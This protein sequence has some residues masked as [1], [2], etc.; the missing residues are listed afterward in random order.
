[1][2]FKTISCP[3]AQRIYESNSPDGKKRLN[4]SHNQPGIGYFE[5]SVIVKLCK[6]REC[7]ALCFH[8]ARAIAAVKTAVAVIVGTE[9]G[10]AD[11]LVLILAATAVMM[12]FLRSFAMTVVLMCASRVTMIVMNIV[13]GM[14]GEGHMDERIAGLSARM[15]I[16]TYDTQVVPYYQQYRR[17]FHQYVL[18]TNLQM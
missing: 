6:K 7:A 14:R 15:Y 4:I 18:H 10:K 13:A 9:T 12:M 2:V 11:N 16:E 5:I 17:Y 8:E 1:M 3:S